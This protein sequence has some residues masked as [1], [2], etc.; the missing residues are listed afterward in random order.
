MG[1]YSL[2]RSEP[3]KSY[4]III[5]IIKQEDNEWHIVKDKLLG[6]FTKLISSR[7]GCGVNIIKTV[8]QLAQVVTATEKFAF[9]QPPKYRQ[10]RCILRR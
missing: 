1:F 2:V 9:Q 3:W 10:R 4:I 6:H 7:D 8:Y 5:I